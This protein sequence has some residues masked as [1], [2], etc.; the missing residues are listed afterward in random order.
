MDSAALCMS[1]IVCNDTSPSNFDASLTLGVTMS[2]IGNSSSLLKTEHDHKGYDIEDV[3][4][5]TTQ[6]ELRNG[7]RTK[8]ILVLYLY[9]AR[10]DGPERVSPLVDTMTGSTTK[11]AFRSI[12]HSN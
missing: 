6:K 9:V 1:E 8:E 12:S 7:H 5:I 3:M 11:A 4:A 10:V 2:A